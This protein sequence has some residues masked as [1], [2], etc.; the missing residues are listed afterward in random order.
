MRNREFIEAK[1]PDFV[2]RLRGHLDVLGIDRGKQE[3]ACVIVRRAILLR[4][5]LEK[6]HEAIRSGE[7]MNICPKVV[8]AFLTVEG[9][10]HGVRS[11]ESLVRM[12]RVDT[13]ER[14][15]H[16]GSLPADDQLNM[17]VDQREFLE[18]VRG[19]A[20]TDGRGI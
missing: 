19:Q 9:F 7:Q 10:R 15:L 18:I 11:M 6:F 8:R 2:S 20:S 12:C 14:W 3:D 16:S 1:G 5:F 4:T 13:S 17:H